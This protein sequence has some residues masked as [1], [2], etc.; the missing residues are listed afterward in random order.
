[1]IQ[2]EQQGGADIFW[3]EIAPSEHLVQIY[4]TDSAFL[5]SLEAFTVAGLCRGEAVLVIATPPH[6]VA[7]EER[8]IARNI[9]VPEAKSVDQYIALDANRTLG[10]FM[11][12]GWPDEILFEKVVTELLSRA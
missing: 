1:M 3:A 9:D 7:L 10:K 8:L 2:F 4:D 5:D 12:R 6:L 11:V